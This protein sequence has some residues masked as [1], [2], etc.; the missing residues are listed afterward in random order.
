MGLADQVDRM[1]LEMME[2]VGHVGKGG[3]WSADIL[4]ALNPR[5]KWSGRP[6]PPVTT[7][8]NSQGGGNACV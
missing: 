5:T 3:P 4:A 7:F 8:R 2:M 6:E 1:L